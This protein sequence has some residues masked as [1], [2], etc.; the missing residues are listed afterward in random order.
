[1]RAPGVSLARSLA[2][3]H[4]ASDQQGANILITKGGVCKLADF[5]VATKLEGGVKSL[6]AVGTPYWSTCAVQAA[7]RPS[8]RLVC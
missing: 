2:R 6:S 8:S 3:T 1:M 5:G 4:S 7:R